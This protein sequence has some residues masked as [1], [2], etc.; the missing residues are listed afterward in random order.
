MNFEIK[1]FDNLTVDDMYEIAKSRFEVFVCEQEITCEQDFDDK[2]KKC[3]HVMLKE[4]G[5]VVAYSRLV[6]KGMGYDYTSIGRVLVLNSHRRKGI[7][8]EMMKACLEFVK[9]ELDE[10][11]VVL[12]AQLYVKDLYESVGFKAISD[13]YNEAN[14][15]HVKM[16]IEL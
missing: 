5:R 4:D 16:K 13:I 11:T 1:R 3:H 10:N 15:P 2:D 14:I 7:A 6:P 9:N 12:S 8:Q